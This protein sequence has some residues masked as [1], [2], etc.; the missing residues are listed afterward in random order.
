MH[1]LVSP[2]AGG[3]TRTPKGLLPPDFESGASASSAT[4]ASVDF[5]P[6]PV[7]PLSCRFCPGD[8]LGDKSVT[9]L[10]GAF[11]HPATLIDRMSASLYSTT[12]ERCLWS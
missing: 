5:S 10:S 6:L 12:S 3:G 11:T 7:F 9:E 2:Y 1:S 8:K 4:P